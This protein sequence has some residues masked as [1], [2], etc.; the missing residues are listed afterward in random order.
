M[1]LSKDLSREAGSLS[2]CCPNP[3]GL[4]Q[5][6]VSGFISPCWSPGLRG[7]LHPPPF[8]PVYLCV[9]VGTWCATCTL[10][11][12][13]SATLSPALLVYL[14]ECGA[15]GSAIGQTACPVGPTLRHSQSRHGNESP[16]HPGCPSPPLL[17]FWMNVYFL[18]PWCRTSL[19]FNFLSVLV[20]GGGTVCLP[21][22]PSWFSAFIF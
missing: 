16:L 11:A 4:F 1:G 19:L 21:M 18:F 17:P 20:V 12:P 2:C 7:L 22:P 13:F 3:H 8:I 5:S 15:T 6:E 9:S 14:Q 10:P